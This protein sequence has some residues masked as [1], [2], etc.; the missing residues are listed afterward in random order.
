MLNH[1]AHLFHDYVAFLGP[2]PCTTS[3]C[4]ALY[5]YVMPDLKTVYLS[6]DAYGSGGGLYMFRADTKADFTSGTLYAAKLNQTSPAGGDAATSHFTISWIKLGHGEP[7]ACA[8]DV[9]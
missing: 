6:D 7:H 4:L 9:A 8:I 2:D 1:K 3:T 5:S